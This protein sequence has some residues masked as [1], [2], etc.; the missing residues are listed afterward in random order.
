VRRIRVSHLKVFRFCLDQV[1]F[2]CIG[3]AQ[4]LSPLRN[5]RYRTGEFNSPLN[6][7]TSA[8]SILGKS[9]QKVAVN[10][11]TSWGQPFSTSATACKAE[12]FCGKVL[13]E[14]L[15]PFRNRYSLSFGICFKYENISK[16]SIDTPTSSKYVP[17]ASVYLVPD[18]MNVLCAPGAWSA[19]LEVNAFWQE[20]SLNED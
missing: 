11:F 6:E 12:G 8:K 2:G 17:V 10:R 20:G 4:P 1:L 14:K 15:F 3:T 5:V 13:G 9:G 18:T 16:I 19:T 7:K